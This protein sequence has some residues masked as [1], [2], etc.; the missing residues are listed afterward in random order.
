MRRHGELLHRIDIELVLG[1][2]G[3][4]FE[5]HGEVRVLGGLHEAEMALGQR[6]RSIARDGA[7]NWNVEAGDRVRHEPHMPLAAD[8]VQHHPADPH[9]TLV[10]REAA[11]DSRRRLRL[12]GDIDDQ[13]H[14]QAEPRGEIGRRPGP[15]RRGGDAV[16]QA[17]GAFDD[18]EVGM[19]GIFGD[20]RIDQRQAA[21]PSCRD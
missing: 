21:W 17:H 10:G 15:E 20:Q 7:E 5:P 13:Q 18:E 19:R 6:E 4:M 2:V 11:H 3:E 8:A 14:R 1:H 9:V 16:E 12:P